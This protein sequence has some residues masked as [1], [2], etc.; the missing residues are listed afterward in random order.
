MLAPGREAR[1][2]ARL[3]SAVLFAVLCV[4]PGHGQTCTEGFA[5]DRRARQCVDVD[6]CRALPDACRGD[7]VCVNQNGGYLCMPRGMYS[8]SHRPEPQYPQ[9]PYRQDPYRQDPY[10]QDPYRPP[11][12]AA[13]ALPEAPYPDTS[14]GFPEPFR[15]PAAGPV[16]PSYPRVR[17]STPCI[18]GYAVA[19]DGHL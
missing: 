8:Q 18:L 4:Q 12:A 2:S 10:R 6:E 13:P 16:E 17:S 9:E 15:P 5:Y 14:L 7:M 1:T 19:E 3:L 11:A